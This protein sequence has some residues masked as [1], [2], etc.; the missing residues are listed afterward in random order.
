MA[1]IEQ[2]QENNVYHQVLPDESEDSIQDPQVLPI[3]FNYNFMERERIPLHNE[4]Y[5]RI[6]EDHQKQT[7]VVR[8]GFFDQ[9]LPTPSHV[10]L[11]HINSWETMYPRPDAHFEKSQKTQEDK[12]SHT[13]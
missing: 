12:N 1:D 8:N 6:S 4:K 9:T 10:M 11:N 5:S 2:H 13:P 3:H 7:E